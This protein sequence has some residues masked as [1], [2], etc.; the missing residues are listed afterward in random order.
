M[1]VCRKGRAS[2]GRRSSAA[3]VELPDRNADLLRLV[4]E[5]RR[6]SGAGKYDDAD[7]QDFEH[8]IV[9]LERRCLGI[10]IPVGLEGDWR[11]LAVVGPASRNAICALRA[12]DMQEHHVGV[13]GADLVEPVPDR[14]MIVEV[15][16]ARE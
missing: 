16:A 10:A 3:L 4:G 15:E 11:N 12:D 8:L 14:A 2:T 13:L 1:I 9:A 6:D 5:V 7:R